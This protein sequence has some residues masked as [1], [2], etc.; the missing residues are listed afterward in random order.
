MTPA[1]PLPRRKL[2]STAVEVTALGFG[3]AAL[4]NL[5]RAIPDATAQACLDAALDAGIGYVDTA[6]HYGQGLSERR[7]GQTLGDRAGITVSSKVG[8]VLTPVAPSPAGT[9]RHGFIDGDPFEPHFDYSYDGVMRSFESSRKRL[10]REHI[11]ILLTHDLGRQTH[12]ADAPAHMKA[13]LAGGYKAM[14]DLKAQGLIGAIGLGVNEW[15]VCEEVMA[16]ADL[17]VILLAGRYTLLEQG[18]L[19]S[20]LPLCEAKGVSVIVGGPFNS[21]ILTGGDHYDYGQVPPEIC[22]RVTKLKAVCAAHDVPLAAA[23]LQFPLAHPAVACVIPGMA[24]AAEV[25]ANVALFARDIPAALW[26]DLKTE[27]LLHD[28]APIPK[29]RVLT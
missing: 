7:V 27:G 26:D 16:H 4:G 24:D 22:T 14:R 1:Y 29:A 21:G 11:D 28:H 5:Y 20:F 18:A 3:A 19:E 12:G 25:T 6:P 15:Q 10:K 2:G 17:D 13:F 9:E 8:R 23:A